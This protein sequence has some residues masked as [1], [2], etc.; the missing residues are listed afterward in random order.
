MAVE[1]ST[2]TDPNIHE[3]KGVAAATAG[4]IYRAN[5][6]GSGAWVLLHPRAN[7]HYTDLTTPSVVALTATYAVIDDAATSINM[8]N[9]SISPEMT[10]ANGRITYTGSLTRQF[11]IK[12]AVSVDHAAG[13]N[14]DLIFAI[15]KNG[16]VIDHGEMVMTAASGNKATGG[17]FADVALSTNDY[18]EV[19]AKSSVAVSMNIYN[20][21]CSAIGEDFG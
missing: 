20:I 9:D 5:G 14:R 8:E 19:Y 12:V 7:F 16:S 6:T 10:Y 17:V 4:H 3:P 18:I 21:Y 11:N 1:H 15:Y 2:I 13:V